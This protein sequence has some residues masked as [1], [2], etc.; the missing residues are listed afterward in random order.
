M[1]SQVF[2]VAQYKPHSSCTL[3]NVT[4]PQHDA[5]AQYKP[6]SSCT[7]R[8][9]TCPQHDADAQSK[10]HSSCT[11]RNVTCPQ[12]D[13]VAQS[14]P[15]SNCALRNVTCSQHDA[16][17]Q[18]KPYSTC[19]L[20][21]VTCSQRDAVTQSKPHSSCTPRNVTCPQRVCTSADYAG[22]V[23][24][25]LPDSFL[26]TPQTLCE[27]SQNTFWTLLKH[28]LNPDYSLTTFWMLP[29][30]L[31]TPWIF[32]FFFNASWTLCEHYL[33]LCLVFWI[34]VFWIIAAHFCSL[35]S[36]PL[37][38]P[39]CCCCCWEY[40]GLFISNKT[41]QLYYPKQEIQSFSA[42]DSQPRQRGVTPAYCWLLS[43]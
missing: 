15:H 6:H 2:A 43:Y 1:R 31:I 19:T 5:V 34:T 14:K 20:R 33:Y 30:L 42:W 27:C 21:N 23:L 39:F 36:T 8:N 24:K 22:A 10:P 3:R 7:L 28:F 12:H 38:S 11:L 32:F 26:T 4:C 18:C 25:P 37:P 16:V 17:A 9:V 35:N 29:E 13:A 40:L 41:K